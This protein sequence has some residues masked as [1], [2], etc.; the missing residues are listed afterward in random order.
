MKEQ[1]ELK[2]I[3]TCVFHPKSIPLVQKYFLDG[4]V[5]GPNSKALWEILVKV[6]QVA[7]VT[8]STITN[9]IQRSGNFGLMQILNRSMN[10]VDVLG[11]E[12]NCQRVVEMWGEEMV[13]MLVKNNEGA[14]SA[15]PLK[16]SSNL[17]SALRAIHDRVA[18]KRREENYEVYMRIAEEARANSVK[19]IEH[20]GLP[21]PF[22]LLSALTSGIQKGMRHDIVGR[23]GTGKTAFVLSLAE[24]FVKNGHKGLFASLEMGVTALSRRQLG[25]HIE[26]SVFDLRKGNLDEGQWKK[27]HAFI[28]FQKRNMLEIEDYRGKTIEDIIE[29]MRRDEGERG[30]EF[31]ILDFIQNAFSRKKFRSRWDEVG[32]CGE[33]YQIACQDLNIVGIMASQAKAEVDTRADKRP[34][35]NDMAYSDQ[36]AQQCENCMGLYRPGKYGIEKNDEGAIYVN[37]YTDI[38]ISK[39]RDGGTGEV[40]VIF[41]RPIQRF[42]PFEGQLMFPDSLVTPK[43]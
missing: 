14:L 3:G 34:Y 23:P 11:L 8:T 29:D 42:M 10:E 12:D 2:V 26:S 40:P 30:I 38:V 7:E 25:A 4:D 31:H 35:Y 15:N 21:T 41:N 16:A 28:E 5:L 39:Q 13:K 17:I 19:Q 36:L 27:M 32:Y 24:T 43:S 20:L 1:V 18:L 33:V 9:G 37:G 6:N 22:P